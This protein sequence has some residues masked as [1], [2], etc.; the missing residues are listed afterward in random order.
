VYI[1]DGDEGGI[2]L[3]FL[4]LF[5]VG[6]ELRAQ[7]KAEADT[8]SVACSVAVADQTRKHRV[9]RVPSTQNHPHPYR[10]VCDSAKH[11][12]AAQPG[13]WPIL[14]TMQLLQVLYAI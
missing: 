6:S 5:Q 10:P 1:G 13:A 7:Q 14:A 9:R 8:H 3:G 2:D 12:A 4:I 11:H